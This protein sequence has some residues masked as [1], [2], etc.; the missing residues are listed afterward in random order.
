[1]LNIT[2]GCKN[3]DLAEAFIDFYLSKDVQQAEALDGVDSPVNTEVE[4]TEEQAANFTY[5]QEMVDS[6][7]LPDWS[8]ITEKKADWINR[9]NELFSVQ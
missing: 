1:M 3:K 7:I 5:G 6:L 9:W 8:L 2:K 4:L